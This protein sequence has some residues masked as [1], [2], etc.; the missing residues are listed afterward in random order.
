MHQQDFQA[1]FQGSLLA[2]PH[3]LDLFRQVLHINL[4]PPPGADQGGLFPSPCKKVSVVVMCSHANDLEITQG[5][6]VLKTSGPA[7]L[8]RL[9][10]DFGLEHGVQNCQQFPHAGRQKR[11]ELRSKKKNISNQRHASA[12]PGNISHACISHP[13]S[14]HDSRQK[15]NPCRRSRSHRSRIDVPVHRSH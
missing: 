10:G 15:I 12:T 7:L 2:F 4:R 6:T 11:M 1:A 8:G 3:I 5:A 9:P 14:T 13:R